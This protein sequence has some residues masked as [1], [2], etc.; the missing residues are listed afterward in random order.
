MGRRLFLG[1]LGGHVRNLIGRHHRS[2]HVQGCPLTIGSIISQPQSWGGPNGGFSV[3]LHRGL[4]CR[5][6]YNDQIFS[7]W[8]LA[9]LMPSVE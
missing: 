6:P 5:V 3:I 8:V 1:V 9:F 7:Y 2:S 4:E